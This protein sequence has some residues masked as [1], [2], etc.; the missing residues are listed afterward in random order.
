M[1]VHSVPVHELKVKICL[2][3]PS[4]ET[5]DALQGDQDCIRLFSDG[6][7]LDGGIGAV[8]VMYKPG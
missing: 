6:L 2:F 5:E 4:E 7:G 1:L 3:K 8:A